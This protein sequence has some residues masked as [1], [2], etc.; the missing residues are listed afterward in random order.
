MKAE[1][2]I[3]LCKVYYFAYMWKPADQLRFLIYKFQLHPH[4]VQGIH[5]GVCI[6]ALLCVHCVHLRILLY[7]DLHSEGTTLHVGKFCYLCETIFP[8]FRLRKCVF[9]TSVQGSSCDMEVV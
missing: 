9:T 2:N 7:S 6:F 5:T 8:V 1:E 4:T 3:F